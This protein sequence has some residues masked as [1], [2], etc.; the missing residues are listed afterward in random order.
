[1]PIRVNAVGKPSMIAT[2]TRASIRRPSTP[3]SARVSVVSKRLPQGVSTS[4]GTTISAM[5][6]KPNRSSLRKGSFMASVLLFGHCEVRVGDV[7]HFL[8]LADVDFLD[9]LLAR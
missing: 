6:A 1:M 3:R 7:D 9:V 2:T 4:T 5:T 8:Q